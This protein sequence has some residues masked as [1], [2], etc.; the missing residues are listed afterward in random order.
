MIMEF[1]LFKD[2]RLDRNFPKDYPKNNTNCAHQHCERCHGT[3]KDSNGN[4]C[5][6]MI[7]CRCVRCSPFQMIA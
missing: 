5:V 7:S 4:Q 1:E 2:S 6:H 3:G